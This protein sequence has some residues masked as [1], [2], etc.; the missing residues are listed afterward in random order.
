MKNTVPAV[1][2][3]TEIKDQQQTPASEPT[4]AATTLSG[5]TTDQ[6][7][8]EEIAA[9]QELLAK[10]AIE[11]PILTQTDTTDSCVTPVGSEA[12]LDN[13]GTPAA[14]PQYIQISSTEYASYMRDIKEGFIAKKIK[15]MGIDYTNRRN[16]LIIRKATKLYPD[17][18]SDEEVVAY[19]DL[20]KMREAVLGNGKKVQVSEGEIDAYLKLWSGANPPSLEDVD[21]LIAKNSI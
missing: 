13:T 11:Q 21:N 8:E 14:P 2:T 9:A 16:T 18:V 19:Y 15:A 4:T 3:E 10:V 1:T 12:T 17:F 20:Y 7:T 5:P 6:P